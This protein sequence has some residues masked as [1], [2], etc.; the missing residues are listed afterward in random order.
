MST[1]MTLDGTMAKAEK[2]I[3]ISSKAKSDRRE[4]KSADEQK[5]QL[6]CNPVDEGAFGTSLVDTMLV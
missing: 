5:L 6:L 4:M 2:L 3:Y 1:Q